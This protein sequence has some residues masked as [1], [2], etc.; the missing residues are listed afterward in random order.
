MEEN[1]CYLWGSIVLVGLSRHEG[2]EAK[3]RKELDH[4]RIGI[5]MLVCSFL[6]P[7]ILT[8]PSSPAAPQTVCLHCLLCCGFDCESTYLWSHVYHLTPLLTFPNQN[9][10]LAICAGHNVPF[11]QR[12]LNEEK[13]NLMNPAAWLWDIIQR[14]AALLSHCLLWTNVICRVKS[15]CCSCNIYCRFKLA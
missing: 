15:V 8:P 5:L 14:A 3:E 1:T 13:W 11:V 6:P 9:Q 2:D 7:F 4:C 10:T 12:F